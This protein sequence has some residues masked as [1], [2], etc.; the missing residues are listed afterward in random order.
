MVADILKSL[1]NILADKL[2]EN[3]KTIFNTMLQLNTNLEM[4]FNFWIL[5]SLLKLHSKI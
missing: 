5:F 3:W 2:T 4:K 1:S